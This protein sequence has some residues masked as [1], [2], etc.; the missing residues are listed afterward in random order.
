[1]Y[2][3]DQIKKVVNT[4]GC[5]AF[6][7]L[8]GGGSV[9]RAIYSN[10]GKSPLCLAFTP[11]FPSKIVPIDLSRSGTIYVAS[12]MYLAHLGYV[13]ITYQ[14]V[15]NA[16]VGCCGASGFVLLKLSGTGIV[17]ITAGGTAM[18]K[19]LEPN[20]RLLVNNESL[21]AF[22]A[23]AHFSVEKDGCFFACLGLDDFFTSSVKGTV[24][25]SN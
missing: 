10:P 4:G 3:S 16:W 9:I 20:E 25:I 5:S 24:Y 7:R 19:V 18:E 17:F 11:E 15:K 2:S 8:L 22:A 13:H 14:V 6:K 21:L 1:M 12:G 23:T